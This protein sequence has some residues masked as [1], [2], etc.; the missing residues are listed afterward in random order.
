MEKR[1]R[2]G[3]IL[4]FERLYNFILVTNP[5]RPLGVEPIFSIRPIA[6]DSTSQ[7][8]PNA[9][10]KLIYLRQIEPVDIVDL[11]GCRLAQRAEDAWFRG[12]RN[13]TTSLRFVRRDPELFGSLSFSRVRR[14]AELLSLDTSISSMP[15][16]AARQKILSR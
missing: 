6:C 9:A 1:E 13:P 11:P 4:D 10:C 12:W 16:Q 7:F 2:Q 14:A 3:R 5:A 15:Q 8:L